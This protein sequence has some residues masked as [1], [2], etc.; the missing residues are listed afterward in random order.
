[1]PQKNRPETGQNPM[2]ARNPPAQ[3]SASEIATPAQSK[4]MSLPPK[5][6]S[7]AGTGRMSMMPPSYPQ[8]KSLPHRETIPQSILAPHAISFPF[9]GIIQI[10]FN[11][12]DLRLFTK[13]PRVQAIFRFSGSMVH[14]STVGGEKSALNSFLSF[15]PLNR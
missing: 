7:G 6:R 8:K 1:M 3:I 14:G 15:Q 11:G 2:G 4:K 10:R 12:Y 9:A 13:P 5:L